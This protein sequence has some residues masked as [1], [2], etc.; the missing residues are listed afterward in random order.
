MTDLRDDWELFALRLSAATSVCVLSDFDGTLVPLADHPD[1][2]R[3]PES[4]RR[5]L[6]RIASADRT[7]AGIVSGRALADLQARIAVEGIWYVGNHGFEMRSPAGEATKFYEIR[8][9]EYL[10]AVRDELAAET[11]SVPG[12]LLEHKGPVIAVHY[13]NVAL[14]K[15]AEVERAFA[16]VMERHRQR[17]MV[18]HGDHVFEA[19]IRGAR[20]K[21]TAVRLIRR[22][23][24]AGALIVYFGDDVTD[25]DVFRTLQGV[26]ISVEV[27]TR[28]STLAP[29][30]L[31]DPGAVWEVLGRL[32]EVL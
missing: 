4:G 32:I 11:A 2:V 18:N 12:V 1:A 24:P 13:R 3:L 27:G 23:L 5:I 20:N 10:D 19:A 8:D 29:Y 22:E 25:R 7:T 28:H 17:L 15:I 6:E 14:P 30:T 9:V 31:P 26:G 21:G 16:R